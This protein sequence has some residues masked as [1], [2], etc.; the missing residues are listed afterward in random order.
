MKQK[1]VIIYLIAMAILI[2]GGYAL[3]RNDKTSDHG[4]DKVYDSTTTNQNTNSETQEN[5]VDTT[6]WITYKN[7]QFGYEVKYPNDWLGGEVS[8]VTDYAIFYKSNRDAG[9]AGSFLAV[10]IFKNEHSL[11]LAQWWEQKDSQDGAKYESLGEV[12][13]NGIRAYRYREIGGM[14]EN[15]TIFIKNNN[16]FDVF[17]IA[18]ENIYLGFFNSLKFNN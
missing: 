16:I 17:G 7:T 12:K 18:G 2:I 8:V 1:N 3:F 4:L 9:M 15:H 14:G 10:R 6:N 11:T 13:V 5:F